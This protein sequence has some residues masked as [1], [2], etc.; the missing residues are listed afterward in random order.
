[1]YFTVL[2]GIQLMNSIEIIIFVRKLRDFSC[3][4]IAMCFRLPET[5]FIKALEYSIGLIVEIE[6]LPKQPSIS[7]ISGADMPVVSG[8]PYIVL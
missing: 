4:Y 8:T 6:Q 2:V 7:S 5:L 3:V 1:M